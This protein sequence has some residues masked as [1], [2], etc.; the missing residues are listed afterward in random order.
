MLLTRAYSVA[1]L[2]RHGDAIGLKSKKGNYLTLNT[3][4]LIFKKTL[5]NSDSPIPVV[6]AAVARFSPS[7]IE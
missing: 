7:K 4:H 3:Y 1:D 2:K 5:D 6:L